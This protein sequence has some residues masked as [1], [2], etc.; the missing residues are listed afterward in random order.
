[1]YPNPATHS[2]HVTAA[3]TI[4]L[5]QVL[6]LAGSVVKE[7]SP[8]GLTGELYVSDIPGGIY[9]VRVMYAGG[10]VTTQKLIRE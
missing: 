7:I 5:I 10:D 6:N 1:M 8:N 2:V 4:Q 3:K 9:L